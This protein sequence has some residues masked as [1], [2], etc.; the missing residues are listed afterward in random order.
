LVDEICTLDFTTVIGYSA[1][2]SKKCPAN[3]IKCNFVSNTL[4]RIRKEEA[5]SK[6]KM[7]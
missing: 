3:D 4:I 6:K 7:V 1:P 2:C 5:E